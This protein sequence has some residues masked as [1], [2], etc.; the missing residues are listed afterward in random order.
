MP[1]ASASTPLAPPA[2]PS[3]ARRLLARIALVLAPWLLIYACCA[4]APDQVGG[5]PL[6]IW[7]VIEGQNALGSLVMVKLGYDFVGWIGKHQR[8]ASWERRCYLALLAV[9][10]AAPCLAAIGCLVDWYEV[11][12]RWE[13]GWGFPLAMAQASAYVLF[14]LTVIITSVLRR[15][16]ARARLT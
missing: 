5:R 1:A 11:G 9:F 15:R 8:L 2:A 4:F 12:S 7:V 3:R 10:A 6:S 13:D 14:C 16:A